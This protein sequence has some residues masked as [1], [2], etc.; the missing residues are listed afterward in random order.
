MTDKLDNSDDLTQLSEETEPEHT[1]SM[2]SYRDETTATV[3]DFRKV[4]LFDKFYIILCVVFGRR[5][6]YH[7]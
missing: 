3:L 2:K 4:P 7:Q 5:L 6:S 1:V